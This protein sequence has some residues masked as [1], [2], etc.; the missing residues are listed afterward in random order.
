MQIKGKL[1]LKQR[2]YDI[3]GQYEGRKKKSIQKKDMRYDRVEGVTLKEKK[4][5]KGTK[6]DTRKC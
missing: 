4:I 2:W 3:E 1:R 5:K 6:N